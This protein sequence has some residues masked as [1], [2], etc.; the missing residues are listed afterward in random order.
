MQNVSFFCK[1]FIKE[2]VKDMNLSVLVLAF[3]TISDHDVLNKL[4]TSLTG[5]FLNI[6]IL[7]DVFN[8]LVNISFSL[9]NVFTLFFQHS[10]FLFQCLLLIKILIQRFH[11]EFFGDSAE[12]FFFIGLADKR[13]EL[14]KPFLTLTKF[15]A[16]MLALRID[17]SLSAFED[18]FTECVLVLNS[19][20]C[21]S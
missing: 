11:T 2:L 9:F 10:D 14:C 20:P 1:S 13:F 19:K 16:V 4:Q 7:L 17:S 12:E 5:K 6:D 21:V 15:F 8:E 18:G 3:G